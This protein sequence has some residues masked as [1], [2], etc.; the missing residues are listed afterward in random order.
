MEYT[1][2]IRKLRTIDLDPI[3]GIVAEV[4][5]S[6]LGT[7]AEGFTGERSGI[8][9]FKN[10]EINSGF[11]PYEHLTEPEVIAWAK[12]HLQ[13][14]EFDQITEYEIQQDI[15]RKKYTPID[16]PLPWSQE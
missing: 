15:L 9:E 13:T 2:K 4:H 16:A 8:L 7:D 14:P 5:W 12:T 1:W 10:P 6:V 11:V 3:T